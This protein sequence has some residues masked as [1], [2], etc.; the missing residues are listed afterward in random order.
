MKKTDRV[1]PEEK[2]TNLYM[3]N[4]DADVSEDL[5]REK[6][7]EFGKI[8]SLAIAKDEN[9]LCRG[10]AFVNFDNPEDARRAAETVNGT[11]FGLTDLFLSSD[12]NIHLSLPQVI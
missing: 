2:Y 7:A 9:R 11:K 8:V 5:L 3:K 12:N 10:Y 4:L 6:F 1:K